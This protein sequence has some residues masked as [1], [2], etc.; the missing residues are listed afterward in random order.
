[1]STQAI[2]KPATP[3]REAVFTAVQSVIDQRVKPREDKSS[4]NAGEKVGLKSTQSQPY[5]MVDG[6]T[7]DSKVEPPSPLINTS[8]VNAS[9]LKTMLHALTKAGKGGKRTKLNNL[10]TK[11]WDG[12]NASS[13][14]SG[15]YSTVI[16]VRPSAASE[17]A[18]FAAL[19]DE[20]K[21]HGCSLHWVFILTNTGA[22]VP[23][24]HGNI[25]YDPVDNT[26]YTSIITSLAASQK[27][28]PMQSTG[29]SLLNAA[30][31]TTTGIGP[32]PIT[33]HG[34]HVLKIRC[35]KGATGIPANTQQV[36]TGNWCDTNITNAQG[37]Y[38][39]LKPYFES[40]T[41]TTITLEW[42]IEYDIEFRSR[43]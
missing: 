37:D 5:I 2:R 13:S 22:V 6:E 23:Y 24:T 41:N 8:G 4:G 39:Y 14:A 7:G 20:F 12:S 29:L 34:V 42:W 30:A 40:Q 16:N 26:A 32:L 33:K 36:Q 19:Y 38:G 27:T 35:P 17:F 9:H 11:M 43:T 1:M 28:G 10:R 25:S 15:A 3:V 21:V 31:A 18:S